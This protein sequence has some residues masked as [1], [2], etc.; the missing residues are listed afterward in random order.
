MTGTTL[1]AWPTT[2]AEPI[3]KHCGVSLYTAEC[4]VLERVLPSLGHLVSGP[5]S[6][7][8]WDVLHTFIVRESLPNV[9]EKCKSCVFVRNRSGHIMRPKDVL[10]WE[11]LC[12]ASIV[13]VVSG[14]FA[15]LSGILLRHGRI[16]CCRE[17]R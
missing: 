6:E 4:Y 13:N 9:I 3:Y 7:R 8:V 10:D 16:E 12:L 5:Y 17:T 15:F 2:E 14:L 1:L 11:R